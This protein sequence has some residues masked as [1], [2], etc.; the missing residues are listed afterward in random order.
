M[1][2][3][4][5]NDYI[6]LSDF[7][8]NFNREMVFHIIDCYQDSPIY[9]EVTEEYENLKTKVS[10]LVEP[11]ALLKFGKL[12][13]G[14]EEFAADTSVIYALM[15]IGDE[16]SRLSS[17]YF[18]QGDYLAGMLVNAMADDYLFQLDGEVQKNIRIEC[19]LRHL[20]V[21]K[22]LEIPHNIPIETQKT[23]L[24]ETKAFDELNMNVTEGYMFTTVKTIAYI[25]ILTNKEEDFNMQHN[26][27]ECDSVNCKIRKKT[28][29]N[30]KVL[31]GE[32][33]SLFECRENESILDAMIRQGQY[34]SAVCGGRGTCGK[35]KIQLLK[36]KLDITPQDMDIFNKV[37][38]ES[39]YRLSCKAYPKEDCIL[40]L[41]VG[42]E[43]DFEAISSFQADSIKHSYNL[44]DKS[45]KEG[46]GKVSTLV[47]DSYAIGI[48]IGTTTIAV[49]LI[50]TVSHRIVKS[51]TT[52]NKQRIYGAD[53]ITR[54]K[55][56]NDGK[57]EQLKNIIR[58]DLLNGIRV[59]IED[60]NIITDKIT[61]LAIAGNTTMVHLLMGYSCE[62]LGVFPFTPVN[63]DMI[64]LPFHELF[65]SNYL[66]IPVVLLPGISTYVGGDIVAGLLACG[67]DN[68][69]NPCI[70]IDLGTNGEMAIGNK[71]RILVSSTAAGPAFEGGNISCGVGSIAGAIC[72]ISI[73]DKKV[74]YQTI[75]DKT[76]IGICGTGV[77]EITSEL[78][79]EGL[80]DE[81][82]LF[83]A[84]YF[85]SGYEIAL[86]KIENQ[87]IFTQKDVREMQLAK[88]AIRAGIEILLRRYGISY[89]EIDTVYLAGGFGYKLN[90]EK[91]VHIG[92]LP[93]EFRG[94]IKAIGNSSLAGA[95]QYLTDE[96][97]DRIGKIRSIAEEINLSND[98]DFNQLYVEYMYFE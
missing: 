45:T 4:K 71:E 50:G 2:E 21:Q 51:F 92:M 19:A 53:V 68:K 58:K 70:L 46:S 67:F 28:K 55:A 6:K 74:E 57:K 69:V 83:V 54:I 23:I 39:G 59:V 96:D 87:I 93:N 1:Q 22:R 11:V 43:S 49:N 66:N 95:I 33:L 88:A 7:H 82:G 80:I 26:C 34:V 56:S 42:D 98:K 89:D 86:E 9:V 81:T 65:A 37:E 17:Q 14:T 3:K 40:R 48:D 91:A 85:D 77:I 72:N 20:G 27:D 5:L 35:C 15:T 75:G 12:Q 44:V 41:I 78:R 13:K 10:S 76:P 90:I 18:E 31:T 8:I 60:S 16:V 94:K 64:E 52:V 47:D 25:L 84:D 38:L 24:E 79:K 32:E 63:I 73:V 97:A 62:T 30:I 36:G 61:K 29:V